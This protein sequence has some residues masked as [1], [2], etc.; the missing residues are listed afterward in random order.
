MAEV[1]WRDELGDLVQLESVFTQEHFEWAPSLL[2][3]EL[4]HDFYRVTHRLHTF[5]QDV[6]GVDCVELTD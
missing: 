4:V 2:A 1:V 3:P 6:T 5:P